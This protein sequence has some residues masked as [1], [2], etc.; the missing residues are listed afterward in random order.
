M[1]IYKYAIGDADQDGII[2]IPYDHKILSVQLQNNQPHV[3]AAV[4]PTTPLVKR[5]WWVVPTGGNVSLND[6]PYYRTTLIGANGLV[7]HVFEDSN[8]HVR[9][10]V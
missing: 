6:L 9:E 4:D 2:Q 1:K 7:W 8:Y 10:R 5:R 3:W